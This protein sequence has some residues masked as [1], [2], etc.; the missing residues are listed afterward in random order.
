[1]FTVDVKQQYN[2]NNNNNNYL[3]KWHVS[4]HRFNKR[5]SNI[6]SNLIVILVQV[7]YMCFITI[8]HCTGLTSL[9][10]RFF[11]NL[12]NVTQTRNLFICFWRGVVTLLLVRNFNCSGRS[13]LHFK[14]FL[15]CHFH[16]LHFVKSHRIM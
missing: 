10:N 6:L 7:Q 16:N 14:N 4:L 11:D 15:S 12:C 13:L 8:F 3:T 1:M 5:L 9:I 2:N